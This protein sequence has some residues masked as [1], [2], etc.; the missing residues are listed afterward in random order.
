MP[1]GQLESETHALARRIADG[2]PQVLAA[3]K[4]L[5]DRAPSLDLES[6]LYWEALTQGRM[7]AAADHREGLRAFFEE[8]VSAIHRRVGGAN[9]SSR[10]RK[11]F[12]NP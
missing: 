12:R 6:A 8:A 4:A 2:P 5:L 11:A 9:A 10:N 7:I 1:A 3:A